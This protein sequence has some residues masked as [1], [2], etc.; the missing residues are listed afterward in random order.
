MCVGMGGG[1]GVMAY[2]GSQARNQ[3]QAASATHTTAAS[4][5]D[6]QFTARDWGLNPHC[7]RD[8]GG[9]FFFFFLSGSSWA[10]G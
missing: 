3:I 4:M 6:P 10:R 2:I 9:F 7:L 5:L 1:G 8:S